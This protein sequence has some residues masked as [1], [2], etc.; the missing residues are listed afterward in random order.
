MDDG[1]HVN[2][3]GRYGE[4][5]IEKLLLSV[6]MGRY[7]GNFGLPVRIMSSGL[8]RQKD[9]GEEIGVTVGYED[10]AEAVLVCVGNT[11]YVLGVE[12]LV[13][14]CAEHDLLRRKGQ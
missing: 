12:H 8:L 10:D 9:T 4:G 14:V 5:E 7:E 6:P 13:H 1:T 11:T 3:Y 2:G